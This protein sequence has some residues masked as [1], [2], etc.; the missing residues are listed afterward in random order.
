MRALLAL[1]MAAATACSL[2]GPGLR[3]GD[4]NLGGPGLATRGSRALKVFDLPLNYSGT[5]IP[6]D[7]GTVMHCRAEDF[8]GGTLT[9]STGGAWTKTGTPTAGSPAVLYPS[10]FSGTARTTITSFSDSNHFSLG[11]GSDVMDFAGD[12]SVCVVYSTSSLASAQIFGDG[13]ATIGG[14]YM[15]G[16]TSQ[17]NFVFSH[18]GADDQ[19]T[20][21]GPIANAVNI[22]CMGR[23]GTTCMAKR[24]MGTVATVSCASYAP[25]TTIAA[26]IGRY[27]DA[28]LSFSAGSV[29]EAWASSTT[30][31]DALFT[32]IQKRFFSLTTAA[33]SSTHTRNS[34]GTYEVGTTLYG[35]AANSARINTNGM[36]IENSATNYALRSEALN[37]AAWTA[38][39]GMTVTA[40]QSAFRDGLASME[41]LDNTGGANTDVISQ[42][43]TVSSSAGPYTASSWFKPVSGTQTATV[44]FACD[45]SGTNVVTAC[46][47][48]RDDGVACTAERI[49][50]NSVCQAF[51]SF[52]AIG[53]M[54]VTG[55]CT[56]VTTAPIVYLSG[57]RR[58]TSTSTIF[59]GGAQFEARTYATS[60]IATAGT[61][62]ARGADVLTATNPIS[63]GDSWCIDVTAQPSGL[64]SYGLQS[65]PTLWEVGSH[66][67]A[68]SANV[69]LTT[70][71]GI[72]FN[73][74]DSAGTQKA[75]TSNTPTDVSHRFTACATSGGTLHFYVDGVLSESGSSGAGT[76]TWDT[77]PSGLY[78]GDQSSGGGSL[79]GYEKSFRIIR[80]ADPTR[81]Y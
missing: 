33:Y 22:A 29:Y 48:K 31:S 72:F 43:V 26:R 56:S 58:A 20:I 52:T 46:T 75:V 4:P 54:S 64:H 51:G 76:G 3:S 24:N 28:G 67:A 35:A 68:N 45:S 14:W 65:F 16:S 40:D 66:G 12:F 10:G 39:A 7:S 44:G 19:V 1:L 57:G 13:K 9:C 74:Y 11:S 73:V 70:T 79:D 21:S 32:S 42:T 25:G 15:L 63:K 55:T 50:T 61:A 60:Y 78:I 23:G 27:D 71:G 2:G 81:L 49:V 59:A 80:S 38:T 36:L 47:C 77:T 41:K 17:D 30:A 62:T 18:S 34:T 6:D 5:L 53:R 37:N 8:S 69:Q